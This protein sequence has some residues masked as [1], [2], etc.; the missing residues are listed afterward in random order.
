MATSNIFGNFHPRNLGKMIP[1]LTSAYFSKGVGWTTNYIMNQLNI[2]RW[3]A[4]INPPA[5]RGW[6]AFQWRGGALFPNGFKRSRRNLNLI[7]SKSRRRKHHSKKTGRFFLSTQKSA[8]NWCPKILG[9][10]SWGWFSSFG[11]WFSSFGGWCFSN[12]TCKMFF[13]RV[14]SQLHHTEM[15]DT[16][17]MSHI[18]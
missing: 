17:G 4:P 18:H 6:H 8:G 14:D 7:S 3:T 12:T 9:R 5:F 2:K 11:G 16:G 10:G 13:F 1:N 15:V